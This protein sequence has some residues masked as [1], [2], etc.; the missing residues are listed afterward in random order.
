MSGET[1]GVAA[2]YARTPSQSPWQKGMTKSGRGTDRGLGRAE[3][4][5]TRTPPGGGGGGFEPTTNGLKGRC[6]TTELPTHKRLLRSHLGQKA[7]ITGSR[8]VTHN[9]HP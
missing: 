9:R 2:A 5:K 7:R 1:K 8:I 6:S 4:G 3:A